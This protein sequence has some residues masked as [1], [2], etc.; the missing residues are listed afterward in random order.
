MVAASYLITKESPRNNRKK[1]GSRSS[2]TM[3]FL[4]SFMWGTWF[5]LLNRANIKMIWGNDLHR[6]A[7]SIDPS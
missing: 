7:R 5:S 6:E 4:P 3:E 2:E 1:F